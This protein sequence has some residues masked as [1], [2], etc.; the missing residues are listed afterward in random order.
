MLCVKLV[1]MATV[2]RICEL[3]TCR[4]SFVPKRYWQKTCCKEHSRRLRYV[5]RRD[6]LMVA[7]LMVTNREEVMKILR[8]PGIA[9]GEDGRHN[10]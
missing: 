8:E 5:R 7:R 4:A 3:S 10:G 9:V 2:T 6:R 1:Q